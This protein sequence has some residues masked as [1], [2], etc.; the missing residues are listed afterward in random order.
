MG[1]PVLIFDGGC[2]FCTRAADWAARGWSRPAQAQ[3]WQVLGP[4]RLAELGLS[5]SQAQEAAWWVD[6]NGRLF[7]GHRAVGKAM[8]A[9]KGWRRLAGVLI[10]MPPGS[11]AASGVY[12]VVARWRHRMPGATPACRIDGNQASGLS[13]DGKAD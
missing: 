3:P 7:R 1:G 12:P 5:V 4:E 8:T 11:W 9:G 6:E 13:G 2:G 10:L